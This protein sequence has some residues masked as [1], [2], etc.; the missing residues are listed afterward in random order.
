MTVICKSCQTPHA[1]NYELLWINLAI[2]MTFGKQK[3][4]ESYSGA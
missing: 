4:K 2:K 1:V 3:T